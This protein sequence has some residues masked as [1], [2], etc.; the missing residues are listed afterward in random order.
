M[1]LVMIIYFQIAFARILTVYQNHATQKLAFYVLNK[2]HFMNVK[3]N[4][5]F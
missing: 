3:Q 4:Y 2:H 1:I 5:L